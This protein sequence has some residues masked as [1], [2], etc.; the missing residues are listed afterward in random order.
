[1]GD[2]SYVE[3]RESSI[4]AVVE[5][6]RL[7]PELAITDQSMLRGN[8]ERTFTGSSFTGSSQSVTDKECAHYSLR[9]TTDSH[10]V[11]AVAARP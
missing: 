8:L 1:M 10:P 2:S 11:H 6:S 4:L 7:D 3:S 9:S 5:L